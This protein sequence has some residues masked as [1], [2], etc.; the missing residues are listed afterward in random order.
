LEV[1]QLLTKSD[2]AKYPFLPEAANY[3]KQLLLDITEL[4]KPEYREL[5][6]NAEKQIVNCITKNSLE[7]TTNKYEIEIPTFPITIMLI[8][9]I[10]DSFLKKRYALL[11]AKKISQF[12]QEEKPEKIMYI[13]SFFKWRI[14]QLKNQPFHSVYEFKLHFADYLKNSTIFHEKK[15]KLINR[16]MKGGEVFLPKADVTRLLEEEI[17]K[18]IEK[19]LEAEIPTL[20]NEVKEYIERLRTLLKSRKRKLQ[21]EE[22][23][24]TVLTEAFPPCMKTLYEMVLRG[25]HLS[26]IE[27]FALTTFLINVGMTPENVTTLFKTST[28]FNEKMTK[29]QVEHIAGTRGSRTKYMPPKCDTMR[30]H[31]IC[32][33]TDTICQKIRHPLSYYKRKSRTRKKDSE[34]TKSKNFT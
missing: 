16:H 13:A 12:L 32:R 15:W 29:Y 28:D 11:E 27:R 9:A 19:K 34:E 26:H 30:T 20:P 24:R 25:Q 10:G 2:L 8:A 17:R 7:G 23:P 3:I 33:E 31:N 22:L 4:S 5:L 6:G 1:N 14:K 18:Y 21:Q